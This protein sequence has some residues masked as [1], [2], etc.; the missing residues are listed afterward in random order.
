MITSVN[1]QQIQC[2]VAPR[3]ANPTT[4]QYSTTTTQSNATKGYPSGAG[5]QYNRY[6]L[7][8]NTLSVTQF[9]TASQ[10]NNAAILGTLQESAVRGD[11]AEGDFYGSYYAQSWKGYFTAPVSGSYTF[12]GIA[13]DVF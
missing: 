13:D 4:S 11:I 2:T 10:T 9:V 1:Y 7:S 5:V 3:T 6:N 8:S 12:R